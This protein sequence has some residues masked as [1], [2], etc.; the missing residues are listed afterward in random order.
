[1]SRKDLMP[2]ANNLSLGRASCAHG[3]GIV[4]LG[5]NLCPGREGKLYLGR[6]ICPLG[7]NLCHRKAT[8]AWQGQIVP[9]ETNLCLGRAICA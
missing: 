6:A 4:S 3:G 5:A 7:E 2:R 9:G 1:M 8:C